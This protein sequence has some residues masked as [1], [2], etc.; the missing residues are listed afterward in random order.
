LRAGLLEF[1][2]GFADD[3]GEGVTHVVHTT[4]EELVTEVLQGIATRKQSRVA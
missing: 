4:Q 3:L 2:S 1:E